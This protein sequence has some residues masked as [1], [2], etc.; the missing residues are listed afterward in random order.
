MLFNVEAIV[1]EERCAFTF[2]ITALNTS[3]LCCKSNVGF[4]NVNKIVFICH[5]LSRST[6]LSHS[7]AEL[8]GDEE[9]LP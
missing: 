6:A 9:K 3:L 2:K 1:L 4:S 5:L 8:A 7:S